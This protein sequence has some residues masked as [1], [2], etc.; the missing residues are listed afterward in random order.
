MKIYI[1]V[2][3]YIKQKYK[4][5]DKGYRCFNML[6]LYNNIIYFDGICYRQSK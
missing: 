3:V 2:V 5:I 4:K 6:I 1:E